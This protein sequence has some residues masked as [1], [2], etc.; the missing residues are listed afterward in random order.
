MSPSNSDVVAFG[1]FDREV[2][3]YRPIPD[4]V[5]GALQRSLCESGETVFTSS[6]KCSVLNLMVVD[7]QQE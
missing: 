7:K 6:S 3:I 2:P 5:E 1:A 4:I